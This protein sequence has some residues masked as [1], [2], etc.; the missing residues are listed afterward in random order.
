MPTITLAVST[1]ESCPLSYVFHTVTTNSFAGGSFLSMAYESAAA[2]DARAGHHLA[3][4]WGGVENMAD[5]DRPSDDPE[6]ALLRQKIIDGKPAD[7]HTIK[8]A[9]VGRY[10]VRC[11]SMLTAT[12]VCVCARAQ[13]SAPSDHVSSITGGQV[14]HIC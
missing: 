13:E 9:F 14:D 7:S 10:Q 1:W 3:N 5:H 2:Y 4:R 8:V 12:R 6:V 11:A